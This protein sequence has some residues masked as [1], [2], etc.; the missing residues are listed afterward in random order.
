MLY[1]LRKK[2]KHFGFFLFGIIIIAFVFWVPGGFDS[3]DSG[4]GK[5]ARVGEVEISLIEF[6]TVF[7][8]AEARVR[9][10]SGENIEGEAREQLKVDV[11]AGLIH[12]AA[13]IQV[14]EDEGITVSNQEV[15]A[16]V[17]SER[18]FWKDGAFDLQLYE[19]VLRQNR[20]DRKYYESARRRELIKEKVLSLADTT[21]LL[22]PSEQKA[23]DVFAKE[24]KS[25]DLKE[26]KAQLLAS[27]LSDVRISFSEGLKREFFTS[28]DLELIRDK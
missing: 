16:A 7:D 4:T 28:Y 22:T 25:A 21:V 20:M 12:E 26:I 17:R 10:Q 18:A 1:F 11:L 5:L 13:I 19:Y 6:W 23:V 14:A 2:A 15:A 27:K 8:N 9:E 24:N 3:G